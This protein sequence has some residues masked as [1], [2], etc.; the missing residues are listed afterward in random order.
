MVRRQVIRG[1]HDTE[2]V[3]RR[4]CYAAGLCRSLVRDREIFAGEFLVLVSYSVA[5]CLVFLL[6]DYRLVILRPLMKYVFL[7]PVY[8]LIEA[9]LKI[10]ICLD[11]LGRL[12]AMIYAYP[13]SARPW[14]HLPSYHLSCSR[15]LQHLPEAFRPDR[16][17]YSGN[18]LPWQLCYDRSDARC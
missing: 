16:W 8:S 5:D 15:Y 17:S 3:R 10:M 18:Q 4:G 11:T 2:I 7:N 9:I 13:L 12:L 6:L 14:R 1:G